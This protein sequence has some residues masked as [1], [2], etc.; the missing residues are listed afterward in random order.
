VAVAIAAD[1][2]LATADEKLRVAAAK[3]GAKLFRG[4]Y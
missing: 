4:S 2:A 1:A 3:A